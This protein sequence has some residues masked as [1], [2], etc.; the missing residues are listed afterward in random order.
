[1]HSDLQ[2]YRE[3]NAQIQNGVIA[4]AFTTVVAVISVW[5]M[6]HADQIYRLLD[7]G[8]PVSGEDA[9]QFIYYTGVVYT[10]LFEV[11]SALI[12]G[13]LCILFHAFFPPDNQFQQTRR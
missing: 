5:G 8:E 12:L 6:L 1:M 7:A 10:V 13:I 4:L 2:F 3:R 11:C 9:K